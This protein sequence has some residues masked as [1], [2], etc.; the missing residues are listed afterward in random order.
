MLGLLM[1][2][3]GKSRWRPRI[4]LGLSLTASSRQNQLAARGF[5]LQTLLK[6]RVI[7]SRLLRTQSV[8]NWLL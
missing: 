1:Y 5:M 4:P 2:Q 8:T 6:K 3:S 7:S